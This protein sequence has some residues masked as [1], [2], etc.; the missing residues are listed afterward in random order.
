MSVFENI[1][2]G[3]YDNKTTYSEET[4]KEHRAETARLEAIFKADL[5]EEFGLTGHPKADKLYGIAW[6]YGHSAGYIDVAHYYD[7]LSE[8]L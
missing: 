4:R 1:R 3:L 8:L 2:N 6:S 7:E 5:E